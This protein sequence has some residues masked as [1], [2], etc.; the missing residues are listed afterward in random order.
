MIEQVFARMAPGHVRLLRLKYEQ[1]LSLAEIARRL[2]VSAKA[3][4]SRL[5][6]ARKAFQVLYATQQT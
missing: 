6:R 4:E 3:A 2:G 5:F 1:G